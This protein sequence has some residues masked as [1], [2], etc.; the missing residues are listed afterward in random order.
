MGFPTWTLIG[1]GITFVGA[2][3][4]IILAYIALSPGFAARI[5]LGG[6]RIAYQVKTFTAYALAL[7]LLFSGF[8]LAGVPLDPALVATAVPTETTPAISDIT[9]SSPIAPLETI[10][11]TVEAALPTSTPDPDRDNTPASGAFGGPP[12]GDEETAAESG[13]DENLIEEPGGE[14]TP[15][16]A[17]IGQTTTPPTFTP[18]PTNS[19]T[20][21][22]TATPTLTPTPIDGETA[23]LNLGGSVIWL[24]RSP[25]GQNLVVLQ[26]QEVVILRPGHANRSGI[27]WRE[28]ATGNGTVGWVEEQFLEINGN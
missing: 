14:S 20:P 10:T 11:T 19:P 1:M 18:T 26:D 7:M 9:S 3:V 8:F 4:M 23:V 27:F 24:R 22:A 6:T 12:P 25:G 5:G 16:T 15:T 2:F 13:I 21:T 17:T 28:V